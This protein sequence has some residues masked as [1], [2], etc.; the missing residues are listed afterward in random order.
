MSTMSKT[1]H[2]FP[3]GGYNLK[4]ERFEFWSGGKG[5]MHDRIQ[6]RKPDQDEEIP[7]GGSTK[8][9]EEGWLYEL[10]SP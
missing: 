4:P 5:R 8:H 9:G 2:L 7:D 3:R 1:L 6:F 10:L